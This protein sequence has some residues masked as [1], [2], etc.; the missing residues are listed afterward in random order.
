M[1]RLSGSCNSFHDIFK[2]LQIYVK[3][4]QACLEAISS[5]EVN[6]VVSIPNVDM[7]NNVAYSFSDMLLPSITNACCEDVSKIICDL[8]YHADYQDLL[9]KSNVVDVCVSVF[10]KGSI[11]EKHA[12]M[13]TFINLSECPK[14]QVSFVYL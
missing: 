7:V 3:C 8:S 2:S 4:N 13:V 10:Q 11:N 5:I 14:F 1:N 12:I 9:C 6:E